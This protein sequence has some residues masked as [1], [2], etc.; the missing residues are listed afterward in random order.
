MTRSELKRVIEYYAYRDSG[1]DM[2]SA[3]ADFLD[4]TAPSIAR[5]LLAIHEIID[6]HDERLPDAEIQL[7]AIKRILGRNK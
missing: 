2:P 4:N 6:A 7:D 5:A 1:G 3:W